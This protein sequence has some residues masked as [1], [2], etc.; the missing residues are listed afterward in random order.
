MPSQKLLVP[1]L[2][3]FLF[4][5]PF[6]VKSQCMIYPVDLEEREADASYIVLGKLVDQESYWDA[7]HQSI[8]T[9]NVIEVTAWLKG[10]QAQSQIGVITNG[11][12]V[13]NQGL[14][15]HPSLELMGY[16]EYALLLG[17]DNFVF[18]NRDFR[19]SHPGMVQAFT[20][21]DA[22]GALTKQ[23]G[24]YHD[25][26]TEPEHS[27]ASL[28]QR[29]AELTGEAAL[30]PEGELFS[31][32]VGDTFPLE[33]WAEQSASR[34]API[35]SIAPDPTHA[36][37]IDTGD[38]IT[39]DGSGFGAT[40]GSVFYTNADDGG[41]TLIS[42]GVASDN[43]SWSDA[44]VVNKPAA[45][46]GTGPITIN[47]VASGSD[48]TINYAHVEVSN[49][50]AGFAQSTRQGLRLVD[51]NGSGGYTFLLNTAFAANAAASSA[52][53]RALET[54]IC[55][56]GVNFETGPT[57]ALATAAQDGS[58]VVFFSPTLPN[59]VLG[60]ANTF[61]N[62]SANGA[63][64]QANTVWFVE[65]VD[66]EFKP[67]PPAGCCTWNFGPA[68]SGFLQFDFESV[69][70][71]EI[72]HAHGLR[73]VI[74]SGEVMH[75]AIANGVDAR[76]LSANDIAGGNAKMTYNL[77]PLCFTPA[78]I[79]GNMILGFSEN[80]LVL[81]ENKL[82]LYAERLDANAVRL[83]WEAEN[84]D[85]LFSHFQVLK[86]E[87]GENFSALSLL[88]NNQRTTSQG[89][90]Y[91]DLDASLDQVWYYRLMGRSE[92]GEQ[93]YSEAV[94]VNNELLDRLEVFPT[95]TQSSIHVRGLRSEEGEVNFQMIDLQGKIVLQKSTPVG[96]GSFDFDI[97]LSEL[98]AGVYLYRVSLGEVPV[99][100]KVIVSR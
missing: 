83:S 96:E 91:I 44:Q 75:F 63:C 45:G 81:D 27:E 8:Y 95:L 33:G 17:E 24:V 77:T 9:L 20:V 90:E 2:A 43:I 61:F 29:L 35:T 25:L 34:S 48:L 70:L 78:T 42:S 54:W 79:N 51:Q 26:L 6:L 60:R 1:V 15:C 80:C 19:Q 68:A 36:G 92:N 65:E 57:T 12:I 88:E 64:N 40:A 94:R 16:N 3:V 93:S 55:A 86:S 7:E 18:D 4:L 87:N 73:H 58:D 71:H 98:P 82:T 85:R 32:R 5:C 53:N 39:V 99:T 97:Q 37:T 10:R 50:F 67:D 69:A 38:F 41:A 13:G 74:A 100:G 21:A 23:R 49:A 62:A 52:F 66:F 84:G 72:G 56:T 47:G 31:P 30:T 59:G 46:A 28:L 76:V 11:G 89:L 22:Q 14:I